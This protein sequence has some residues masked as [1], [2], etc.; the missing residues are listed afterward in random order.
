M[1]RKLEGVT[2]KMWLMFLIS[3]Q[4]I[5]L[6]MQTHSI[7][8]IVKEAGGLMIFDV[9]PL[10]YSFTYAVKFLSRLSE[11]GYNVYTHVQLP[12]FPIS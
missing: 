1:I 10:G 2:I 11:E 8:R 12:A 4:A 5:Y 9:K 6:V 3:S 7:P